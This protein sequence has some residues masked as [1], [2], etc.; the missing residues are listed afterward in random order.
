MNLVVDWGALEE[1]FQDGIPEKENKMIKMLM[2]GGYLPEGTFHA[3]SIYNRDTS[4]IQTLDDWEQLVG[5]AQTSVPYQTNYWNKAV[6][7]P[8]VIPFVLEFV[9]GKP[10]IPDLLNK[11]LLNNGAYLGLFSVGHFKDAYIDHINHQNDISSDEDLALLGVAI[12]NGWANYSAGLLNKVSKLKAKRFFF[13]AAKAA[14]YE[15][16]IIMP[17]LELDSKDEWDQVFKN[18]KYMEYSQLEWAAK[19]PFFQEIIQ[20]YLNKIANNEKLSKND[21]SGYY[22]YIIAQLEANKKK[23]IDDKYYDALKAIQGLINIEYNN[24]ILDVLALNKKA[25]A[26]GQYEDYIK[27]LIINE[28]RAG[29]LK[30]LAKTLPKKQLPWLMSSNFKSV[31]KMVQKKL[32]K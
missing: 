4:V 21:A 19:M 8:N 11:A 2:S 18:K 9:K 7:H 12:K 16:G 14:N 31:K 26:S 15:L 25:K 22:Q 23:H 30:H 27:H 32:D 5:I 17:Y 28:T 29:I 13:E 1:L 10:F 20:E 24:H 3:L 6:I